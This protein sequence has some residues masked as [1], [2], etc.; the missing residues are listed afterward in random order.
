[1]SSISVSVGSGADE[2]VVWLGV[3]VVFMLV[4][5][6]DEVD[7]VLIVVLGEIDVEVEVDILVTLEVVTAT[8]VDVKVDDNVLLDVFDK[9][10]V[11][12]EV[13]GAVYVTEAARLLCS[14]FGGACMS[15]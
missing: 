8:E 13:V 11:E 2:V 4:E 10:A 14:F 1:M 12:L 3:D 15:T 9:T 7:V 6:M 5:M